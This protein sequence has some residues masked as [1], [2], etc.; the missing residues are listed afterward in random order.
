MTKNEIRKHLS[1]F[2]DWQRNF[3]NYDLCSDSNLEKK[4]KSI[5]LKTN[6]VGYQFHNWDVSALYEE[7]LR[8]L[9]GQYERRKGKARLQTL[10]DIMTIATEMLFEMTN[11]DIPNWHLKRTLN[12]VDEQQSFLKSLTEVKNDIARRYDL[13]EVA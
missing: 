8:T 10:D 9:W 11:S 4:M 6:E 13:K 1:E 5:Q 2:L 3:V 7:T 12:G